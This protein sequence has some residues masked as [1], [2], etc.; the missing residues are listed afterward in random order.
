ME[1]LGALI[2]QPNERTFN[3]VSP[4][5][6]R[7][8]KAI[9]VSKRIGMLPNKKVRLH[10][11]AC[12]AR[13]AMSYG[14]YGWVSGLPSKTACNGYNTAIWRAL[15]SISFS[16]PSLRRL[17]CGAHLEANPTLWIRQVKLLASRNA[18]LRRLGYN[19]AH[20]ETVLNH[21]V[22]EGFEHYGWVKRG[23][24]WRH[25]HCGHFLEQDVLHPKEWKRIAH[26][27][28]DSIRWSSWIEF[29]DPGR[30]EISDLHLPYMTIERINLT[31]RWASDS[32]SRRSFAIGAVKSSKTA[33]VAHGCCTKCLKCEVNPEWDHGRTCHL[34]VPIPDDAMLRRFPWGATR[35]EQLLA[36]SFIANVE[37]YYQIIYLGSFACFWASIL[38]G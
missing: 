6:D 31:R 11:L 23:P 38:R 21:C 14:G 3:K 2:G 5:K 15:G 10:D 17:I 27:L 28:R 8:E 30:H 18:E 36:D 33:F 12:L 24:T 16:P 7:F 13:P 4:S 20:F 26:K 19:I 35:A 34:Q 37:K 9:H 22:M 32:A 25:E 1:V 29:R